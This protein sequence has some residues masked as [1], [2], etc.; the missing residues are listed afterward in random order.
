VKDVIELLNA[1]R[2][3]G[4][5]V[6]YALFGAIAQ[7]R[8]TQPVVTLDLDVLVQLPAS[9]RTDVL[10]EIY[11]F[12]AAR[13]YRPEGEAIRIGAWPVQFLPAYDALTREALK[14]AQTA[15]M[16]GLPVQVV[17]A[18]HLAAIALSTGR[19]KDNSRILALLESRKTNREKLQAWRRGMDWAGPGS[20]F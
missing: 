9:S 13:G 6:D 20:A 16:S 3:A 5:I 8:Y 11:R 4:V 17:R 14:H 12:C 2:A 18:A 10:G 1:M 19:E 15:E 7:M